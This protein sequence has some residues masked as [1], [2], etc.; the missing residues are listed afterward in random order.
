ME[1]HSLGPCDWFV[2]LLVD[3]L[4]AATRAE[5]EAESTRLNVSAHD[6]PA[7]ITLLR[8]HGY[9]EE[10][11]ERLWVSE[12]FLAK[13][14]EYLRKNTPVLVC[15][16][17]SFEE[18]FRFRQHLSRLICLRILPRVLTSDGFTRDAHTADV[19]LHRLYV[20]ALLRAALPMYDH[21]ADEE[22]AAWGAAVR[23]A[24]APVGAL[25]ASGARETKDVFLLVT[26]ESPFVRFR[27]RC[28]DK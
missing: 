26:D 15:E 21:L 23:V 17:L 24:D 2:L 22:I 14:E 13:Q 5:L 8:E 3:E 20:H 11:L 28:V 6:F 1:L 10:G 9:L 27:V 12:L 4:G 16:R 18:S 25:R 19:V 7:S